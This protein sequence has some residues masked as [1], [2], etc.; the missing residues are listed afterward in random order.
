MDLRKAEEPDQIADIR[1]II[2]K[3][4]RVP[5][6]HLLLFI[7]DTNTWL[8]GSQQTAE[9]SLRDHLTCLLRKLDVGQDETELMLNTWFQIGEG[10]QHGCILFI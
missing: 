5:E 4:K 1:W 6:K 9:N 8:C 2:K 10:V 3:S 7:D